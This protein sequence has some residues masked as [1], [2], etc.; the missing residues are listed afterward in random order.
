[1]TATGVS[2]S[3][4]SITCFFNLNGRRVGSYNLIVVNPDGQSDS[5]QNMFSIGEASPIITGVNPVTAKLNDRV[6]LSIYGQ[7][8]RNNLKVS[9]TKGT[10]E[11]ICTN[12]ISQESSKISCN[13]NLDRGQGASSGDWT[14]TVLNVDDQT[15]GTWPKKFVV[16]NA[17]TKED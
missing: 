1:L 3:A 2:A 11:L 8:F 16:T 7:N 9:F 6:P 12:P 15:R 4:T 17:T 10:K 5:K 14:V 13:L